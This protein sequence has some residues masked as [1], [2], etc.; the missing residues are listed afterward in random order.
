MELSEY[1]KFAQEKIHWLERRFRPII[2]NKLFENDL[3]RRVQELWRS[4]KILQRKVNL[5]EEEDDEIRFM[6]AIL[7]N[8]DFPN[9]M[10]WYEIVGEKIK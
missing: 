5:A 8:Q 4:C 6:Y 9:F 2:Q 3:H 1:T 10:S 7:K